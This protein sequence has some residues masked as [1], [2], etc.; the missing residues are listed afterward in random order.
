VLVSAV[1]PAA[2]ADDP[3]ESI[4]LSPTNK[5][6]EVDAGSTITDDFIILNDGQTAYDF[7]VYSNPYSVDAT[8]YDPDYT[9]VPTNADAY[10]WVSFAKTTWH[11]GPRETI[12]VPFT[13]RVRPDA[14][15]G[16]HYGV[17]FAEVQPAGSQQ[18]INLARKKRVGMIL[19]VTVNGNVILK[20][21]TK[22][23]TTDWFQNQA[24]LTSSV[25]VE[26]TGNTDFVAHITYDVADIFGTKKYSAAKDFTIFPKTTRPIEVGWDKA[27]WL[28]LY[29]TTVTSKVLDKTTSHQSYVLMAPTWFVYTVIA[30]C[31]AGVFYALRNA[32][33]K[34]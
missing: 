12:H 1:T 22:N 16:G 14:A 27:A 20:G 4:T 9:N 7:T 34:K 13:L 24:P 28:G 30:V 19:Q 23:I 33:T 6:Y 21:E 29:K 18:G 31:G 26:N 10:T 32:R 11:A 8:T 2:Y 17:I 15:P 5:R 25:S 3:Q